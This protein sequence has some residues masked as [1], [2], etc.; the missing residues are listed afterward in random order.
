MSDPAAEIGTDE[1]VRLVDEAV[2]RALVI[3]QIQAA[4]AALGEELLGYPVPMMRVSTEASASDSDPE[5]AVQT[6]RPLP[7]I[8]AGGPGGRPSL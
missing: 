3:P 8:E 7:T 2:R 5:D 1:D 4:A 6:R